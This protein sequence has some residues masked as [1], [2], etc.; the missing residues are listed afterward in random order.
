MQ[1]KLTIAIDGYSSCGK[2]T[3]AKAIAKKLGYVYVD[4]GAMYRAVTLYLMNQGILKDKNFLMKQVL[5]ALPNIQIDF[6]FD[7][8]KEVAETMLNG[9]NVETEIR[10][11]AVSQRVSQISTIK[12]VREKL[13]EL[14]Q[15]LGEAGGV[16]MDGRDIGTV[17]FPNADLKLFITA[18]VDIRTERRLLEMKQKNSAINFEDV[19]QNLVERDRVDMSRAISPLIQAKDAVVIDNSNLSETAQFELVLGL[20]KEKEL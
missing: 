19:K 4:S 5:A 3:I 15:Q 12:E 13:V 10:S 9:Q 16:V 18:E 8:Q 2:S 1:K 11:L 17:V 7:P 20:I 6:V 14:Q